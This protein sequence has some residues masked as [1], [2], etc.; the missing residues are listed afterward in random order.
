MLPADE[1]T[2]TPPAAP[3]GAQRVVLAGPWSL[4]RG[5]EL[6]SLT[7]VYETWGEL[8]AA[9][10]NAVLI[11]TGLSP[12]SHAA[13]TAAHPE[14]GWWE[15]V[16]GPG[17]PIDTR[18]WFVVCV[19]SLGSCFGSTG[20]ASLDPRSGR[21]YRLRFPYL[22]VEDIAHAGW[23][24]VRS[25]DIER[26]RVVIGAS[27]GGMSA[28]ALAIE[29]PEAVDQLVT[30]SAATHAT[31]SAI[32]LRSLQREIIR[33]DPAW[34]D[35]DY[36]SGAGPVQGMRLARKLGLISYRSAEE[37][38]IRF[39]RERVEPSPAAFDP[40]F[41]VEA[42]LDANAGKFA[43]HFDANCYLYLSRAMDDFDIAEHG[44][45]AGAGLSRI[46]ARRTLV[47]GVETD[48]LF[49]LY[50]QREIAEG[51]DELGREVE[52]VALPSLQGHDAFLVDTARYTPLLRDFFARA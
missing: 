12:S 29:Y 16:I 20:P 15:Y 50:Q 2:D 8:N 10:D 47:V 46:Q 38:L 17:K 24:V 28:L 36:A 18:R 27:L 30:I 32:A 3:P 22:S 40:Q 31:P 13:A 34:R 1:M 48:S 51:L 52:F 39:G 9:R 49:P 11:Y 19:N 6:P 7:L 23:D 25:L 4:R 43:Q 44:G 26:L 35:G 37:W 14:A 42:Y 21:P 45:S 33:S 41:Q 5:G